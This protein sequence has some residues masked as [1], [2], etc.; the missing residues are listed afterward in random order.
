MTSQAA[1]PIINSTIGTCQITE[2][3]LGEAR[4]MIG[5][6]A[7]YIRLNLV[8][9]VLVL[10]GY[11]IPGTPSPT[12]KG[13]VIEATVRTLQATGVYADKLEDCTLILDVDGADINGVLLNN[14][15]NVRILGTKVTNVGTEAIGSGYAI[16]LKNCHGITIEGFYPEN[17]R[18]GVTMQGV[19]TDITVNGCEC[20]GAWVAA[21]VD[22]H[23]A[24]VDGLKLRRVRTLKT[25]N[26]THGGVVREADIGPETVVA[27]DIPGLKMLRA[28]IA[29]TNQPTR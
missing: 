16:N 3:I 14:C 19:C 7:S 20:S 15:R 17:V 4:V 28:R 27:W 23:G 1:Q 24:M 29:E 5:T 9:G 6:P 25:F 10:G 26:E 13:K 12:L 18:Y 11:S 8:K 2:E 21:D 22:N